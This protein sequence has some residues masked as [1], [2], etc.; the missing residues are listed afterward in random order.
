MRRRH[1]PGQNSPP[2]SVGRFIGGERGCAR[3]PVATLAGHTDRLSAV[4]FSPDAKRILTGSEDN[5]TRLW[6]AT[7]ATE[8]RSILSGLHQKIFKL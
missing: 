3:D 4:A 1:Q 5:T 2:A 7:G 6:E 8:T